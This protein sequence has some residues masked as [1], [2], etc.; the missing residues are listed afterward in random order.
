MNP[1]GSSKGTEGAVLLLVSIGS[2]RGFTAMLRKFSL[3]VSNGADFTSDVEGG[4]FRP[5][6]SKE[7]Q[8]SAG[9]NSGRISNRISLTTHQNQDFFFKD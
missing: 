3:A 7:A 9:R 1:G 2:L 4:C 5:A 6:L 8:S